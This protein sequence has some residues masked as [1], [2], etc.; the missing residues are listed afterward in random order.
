[1]QKGKERYLWAKA[2]MTATPVGA[3]SP[4]GA[5]CFPP[6]ASSSRGENPVLSWT[7][8][9]GV[10]GAVPFLKASHLDVVMTPMIIVFGVCPSSFGGHLA[11]GDLS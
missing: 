3:V 10:F 2:L 9:G 5:S 7:C 11:C 4:L 6:L 1:M 8:D